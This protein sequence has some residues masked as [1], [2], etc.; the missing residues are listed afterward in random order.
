MRYSDKVISRINHIRS[1]SQNIDYSCRDVVIGNLVFMQHVIRATEGLLQCAI[2]H[3]EGSL[4]EYYKNHAEE[5]RGHDKWMAQDLKMYMS[6]PIS[7]EAI[8]MAGSQYYMIKHIDSHALLGYMA[9]MEGYP[10]DLEVL[11]CLEDMHGKELFKTMRYHAEHD[12][13]HRKEL[14]ETIDKHP[15]ESIMQS[16]EITAYQM[17]ELTARL[18][19]LQEVDYV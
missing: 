1:Q 4:H 14:F 7:R 8:E 17:N 15:H 16:A 2:D 9:V 10:L 19:T 3:S 5:E 6:S 12:L 18:K 13:E 11:S